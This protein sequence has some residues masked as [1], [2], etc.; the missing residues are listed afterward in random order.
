VQGVHAK[1]TL[2]KWIIGETARTRTEVDAALHAYRFD[3][4]A[5][6]LYRFV[7]NVVCDWYVEFSKSLLQGEDADIKAETQATTA[8]VLEQCM[9]LLHPFMPF[10]TEELWSVTGHDGMLV[11]ASWP[12][13]VTLED[14]DPEAESEIR[15]VIGFIEAIRSARAQMNVPAG[16]T[17]PVIAVEWDDTAQAAATKN[18][19]LIQRLARID[20][21]TEG[22][23]P[24]GA[25]AVTADGGRYALPLGDVIDIAQ[26]R[27]RLEKSMAKLAKE[28]KGLEGRTNNPNFAASAPPEVVEETRA[29]LAARQDEAAAI[30]AALDSLAELG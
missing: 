15:W 10:I 8:W 28:I 21:I 27:D 24:K 1:N 26:E 19:A 7:W 20:S 6:T 5:N 2:N 9:T 4:A 14:I 29:N 22:P 3:D 16:A 17:I 13:N 18:L 30:Q 12:E 11:H 23:A 25:I